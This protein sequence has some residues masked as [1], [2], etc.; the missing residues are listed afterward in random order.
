MVPSCQYQQV[1]NKRF[2]ERNTCKKFNLQQMCLRM[3]A[4][5]N[6]GVLAQ[7]LNRS[8][9]PGFTTFRGAL[10]IARLRELSSAS[11]SERTERYVIPNSCVQISVLQ[12]SNEN[13]ATVPENIDVGL[14]HP[15]GRGSFATPS[16]G[17]LSAAL[18]WRTRLHGRAS[19]LYPSNR[20]VVK[21]WYRAALL[22]LEVQRINVKVQTHLG[23]VAGSLRF[24]K[25]PCPRAYTHNYRSTHQ[26]E[27]CDDVYGKKMAMSGI[28]L[29]F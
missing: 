29:V 5:H 26:L 3:C 20:L 28:S 19:L 25:F 13:Y 17:T 11:N 4:H 15:T 9:Q 22:F 14:V 21:Y 23:D 6:T 16:C 2:V 10:G 27:H 1:N 8:V 18:L 12:L 24:L 7:H